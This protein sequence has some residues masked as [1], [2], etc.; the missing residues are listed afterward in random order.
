[1]NSLMQ[2]GEDLRGSH[3]YFSECEILSDPT[4]QELA[5][6]TNFCYNQVH[7]L[8]KRIE[9][10]IQAIPDWNQMKWDNIIKQRDGRQTEFE[11][12]LRA[13]HKEKSNCAIAAPKEAV[14]ISK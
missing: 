3:H 6:K 11:Q 1:M 12:L 8:D 4:K 13:Y 14:I 5:I 2:V 10:M 9:E 7:R